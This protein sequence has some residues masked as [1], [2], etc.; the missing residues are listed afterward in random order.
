MHTSPELHCVLES[1]DSLT[2]RNQRRGLGGRRITLDQVPADVALDAAWVVAIAVRAWILGCGCVAQRSERS[3]VLRVSTP[4]F[5]EEMYTYPRFTFMSLNGPLAIHP[6]PLP[7]GFIPL[8][9][10]ATFSPWL[11]MLVSLPSKMGEVS[12]VL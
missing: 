4:C 11:P 10:C 1:T 7:A 3:I 8:L 12:G 9:L 2:V 6:P 5:T